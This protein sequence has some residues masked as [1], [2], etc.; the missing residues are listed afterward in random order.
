MKQIVFLVLIFIGYSCI[1]QKKSPLPKPDNKQFTFST[2]ANIGKEYDESTW[3]EKLAQYKILGISDV[4][5]GGSP[6]QIS[7]LVNQAKKFDIKNI[8][9]VY[10]EYYQEIIAK[11]THEVS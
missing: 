1:H 3:D 7:T 11:S 6:E 2:W 8:V 9:P 10:E 5:V 4:L